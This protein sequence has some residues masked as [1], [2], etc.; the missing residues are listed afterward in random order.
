[1][2]TACNHGGHIEQEGIKNTALTCGGIDNVYAF[3]EAAEM[4]GTRGVGNVL[5]AACGG[6]V[7][8][9][10]L[11]VIGIARLVKQRGGTDA[12]GGK[13]GEESAV[14][15]RDLAES[16]LEAGPESDA[17]VAYD[18]VEAAQSRGKTVSRAGADA[19]R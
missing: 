7:R 5:F 6:S 15:F 19:Q 2:L 3:V 8:Q 18:N 1:M 4:R 11:G 10:S 16:D 9:K 14:G 17:I 13:S 12:R